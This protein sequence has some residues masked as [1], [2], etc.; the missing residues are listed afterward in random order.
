MANALYWLV[1][2]AVYL[3]VMALL[4]REAYQ[5]R[6]DGRAIPRTYALDQP[7]CHRG[8]V[9]IVH[10]DLVGI[11]IG[12]G[13]IAWHLLPGCHIAHKGNPRDRRAW[14]AAISAVAQSRTRLKQFSSSSSNFT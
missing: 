14:W 11:C 1:C 3:V 4:V 13:Q 7:V 12:V 6:L 8:P 9:D 10:D 5:L 2:A